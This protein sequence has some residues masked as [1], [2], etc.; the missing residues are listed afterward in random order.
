MDPV[1][2]IR[3]PVHGYIRIDDVERQVIDS[4]VL[5]RLRRIRQLSGAHLTYPGAQH[6]RFEHSLG[7][8]HLAG[9]AAESLAS[10]VP[11]SETE[12]REIRLAALLH[13]VGHGPFSHL[14]EEVMVER[15]KVHHEDITRQVI[16]E[17]ELR[18]VLERAGFDPKELSEFS[19][20][21]S[22][23]KAEYLNELIRGGLSVDIMDYLLRDSYF[24][25]VEYGKVDVN[26][27]ISSFD[28][29][30]LD[31]A[32]LYAFEALMI[33]RYEMFRAVYFHRTV[34]AAGIMLTRAIALADDELHLT[35]TSDLSRYLSLTDEVVLQS[36]LNLDPKGS[37]ELRK[38]RK[39]AED[40]RDRRLLKCAYEKHVH[41]KDALM[42]RIFSQKK[43]RDQLAGEIAE[44]ADVDVDQVYIDVPTTPS[45]PILSSMSPSS[46]A[47]VYRSG[48][49]KRH[50]LV[51]IEELPLVGAISG[52]FD[53]LRVYT[54]PEYR[55][56]VERAANR[57]FG[58]ESFVAKI[59]M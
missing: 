16:R 14:I 18:D 48:K 36:L 1:G 39:L 38:A 19:I 33:A 49:E 4:Y 40:Y 29:L 42:E 35:D 9:L 46:I 6:T 54:L 26:R 44:D 31:Q 21:L 27:V 59:S 34:R 20:G 56:R 43:I 28:S 12:K 22:K 57:L 50:Q 53:I 52:F 8:M 37:E 30:G 17:T 5:Q 24:T 47:L 32:A 13:D 2:E 7:A 15:R 41:R 3:D 10:K 58:G 55:S 23:R 51:R 45:V 11:L 25:G